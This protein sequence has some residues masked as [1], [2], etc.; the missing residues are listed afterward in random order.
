MTT[1]TRDSSVAR[2]VIDSILSEMQQV[3]KLHVRAAAIT[4]ELGV[5]PARRGAEVRS[6]SSPDDSYVVRNGACSCPFGR[7]HGTCKHIIAVE[8]TRKYGETLAA[9]LN[10]EWDDDIED[11]ASLEQQYLALLSDCQD[12]SPPAESHLT[13]FRLEAIGD[14]Q[15]Q[16]AR[17]EEKR[18]IVTPSVLKPPTL[19]VA[20][21]LGL[22][23]QYEFRREFVRGK[24]DYRDADKYGRRGVWMY[25]ELA[26]GLYEAQ[27]IMASHRLYYGNRFFMRVE[28]LQYHRIEKQELLE[29]LASKNKPT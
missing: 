9:R 10:V 22:C 13:A 27:E 23:P 12:Y 29:C 17:A 20:K 8:L 6:Q 19:W 15:Y 21:L 14:D 2:I 4:A 24:K 28:N 7:E 16:R 3:T 5:R 18:G 11:I 1:A 25:W 26:D